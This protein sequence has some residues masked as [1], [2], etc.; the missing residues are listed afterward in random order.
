MNK[1]QKIILA[2]GSGFLGR[3]LA[4]QLTDQGYEVVVLS[5]RLGATGGLARTVFWDGVTKGAWCAELEGAHAV[6]NLAGR[7]VDCRY[8]PKNRHLILESRLKSTRILALAI[9]D[10]AT[11]PKLWVNAASATIYADTRG[12]L[13]A[14]TETKGVIGEGFS[15]GVCREWEAEF[16]RWILPGT[17]QVCLRVAITLGHDGG[18][19]IPL[20]RLARL[21]LG[22]KQGDGQQ[23]V[24]WL[25]VDDFCGI[26][27][28]ILKGNLRGELYNCAS[29]QP[30]KNVDFMR[31]LRG[32]VGGVGRFVALPAPKCL[33]ELGAWMIRTET[34]LILKSRKVYP[35]NLIREGYRFKFECFSEAAHAIVDDS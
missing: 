35:E 9:K 24:S 27:T 28:G 26:V 8:T 23:Y 20:M 6:I 34:E 1:K 21:G 22:G 3:A 19:M 15:V 14:N 5:R 33:L 4:K 13:P 11:P 30:M 18:A 2:G 17:R 7:S 31:V 29:P 16:R 25:H 12:D 10:C 32:A